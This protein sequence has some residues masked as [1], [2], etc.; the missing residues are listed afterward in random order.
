MEALE[1]RRLVSAALLK[2]I[3]PHS[4]GSISGYFTPFHDALYF[5]AR[6]PSGFE[7]YRSSGV[8]GAPVELVRDIVPGPDSSYPAY[9]TVVG[10][11]LFFRANV[12]RGDELWKSDGTAAGTVRVSDAWPSH[13]FGAGPRDL[14]ALN[15]TLLFVDYGNVLWKSAGTGASTVQFADTLD[16]AL[17]ATFG[18][19]TSRILVTG[20]VAYFQTNNPLT[21]RPGPLWKT[22]GTPAGTSAV[23]DVGAV[24]SLTRLDD[25]RFVIV[26]GDPRADGTGS[27]M[28]LWVS[29]GTPGGTAR[30]RSFAPY[31]ARDALFVQPVNLDGAV[32]FGAKAK[33]ADPGAAAGFELWRTDGTPEGTAL[34]A[35]VNPGLAGSQAFPLAGAG[36]KLLFNATD[37][38]GYRLWAT[39]GTA[40]GT[41]PAIGEA[42]YA[43]S[44]VAQGGKFIVATR[45]ALWVTDGT[46]AG[47]V[48]LRRF[49]PVNGPDV[50]AYRDGVIVKAQ[51]PV[52][53]EEPWFSD[54]T[55]EGTV[56]F[57]RVEPATL[58][59]YAI[60]GATM[61][62]PAVLGDR[63]MFAGAV[64]STGVKLWVTDGTT[65]GTAQVPGFSATSVPALRAGRDASGEFAYV[66]ARN[67]T[68]RELWRA[69]AAGATL[70]SN[71]LIAGDSILD[72]DGTLYFAGEQRSSTGVELYKSDG[73][74][75]GTTLVRDIFFTGSSQPANFRQA[76]GT[77]YFTVGNGASLYKT[78]GTSAGTVLVKE[79]HPGTGAHPAPALAAVGGRLY[80]VIEPAAGA[81]QLWRTDGSAAGTVMVT[82]IGAAL[83]GG[84][85]ML[86]IGDTLYFPAAA[87]DG[88]TGIELWKSDGTAAGTRA[89][90][91]LLPGAEGSRPANLRA[92]GGRVYFSA[93]D[94]HGGSALWA[95]DG[96]AA[97][98]VKVWEMPADQPHDLSRVWGERN[99]RLYFT[100]DDG[101]HG[102]ELWS[103]D[104]TPAGTAMVEDVR[105]GPEASGV[106]HP[107]DAGDRVIFF[108]DDGHHWQEPWVVMSP[109]PTAYVAGRHLFYNNSAFDNRTPGAAAADDAAIA[110]DRSAMVPGGGVGAVAANVSTYGRGI[111]GVMIDVDSLPPGAGLTAADFQLFVGN[112]PTLTAAPAP[113]S[114]TVRR[115][116]GANGSDR[117]TLLFADEAIQNTWLRVTVLP[118]ANTGLAA[119][120][121][122][123]FGSLAGDSGTDGRVDARDLAAVRRA[124]NSAATLTTATDLNRDGRTNA[125][126]LAIVRRNLNRA[127]ARVFL[128]SPGAAPPT[129]T[130]AAIPPPPP[131]TPLRPKRTTVLLETHGG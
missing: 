36:G 47:T 60:P 15:G 87:S 4:I 120:D 14:T 57:V 80:F 11:T 82:T 37:G 64:G 85:E 90:A 79:L 21:A 52:Y 18:S 74:A 27:D 113:L 1:P 3:N 39:D 68:A 115:G 23:A 40:A 20:G 76:G 55:V 6:G 128:P 46:P 45:D 104:G 118:T 125:L 19:L 2:D 84:R 50:I 25:N 112:G 59:T 131:R 91:D 35:D 103:T 31:D 30:V 61:P 33:A 130:A 71:V 83:P 70:L 75:A 126:D 77:V 53:G 26:T 63:A 110:P 28:E 51:D 42:A 129:V 5:S 12:G 92:M 96:T 73:T 124:L 29:D 67:G 123:V 105:R 109:T 24:Y 127:L 101:R 97:G 111:N 93:A 54:G 9:L 7:L 98:T 119:P 49:E 89:V 44:A 117:V 8:P 100:A 48:F 99:G 56:P 108:A 121:V 88:S 17:S 116:A 34:I 95:S 58:G 41:Q 32:Y 10:D 72:P 69:G 62:E 38:T 107:T 22:D 13:I 86:A 122:F 65:G 16:P 114:V 94:G 78:N 106:L 102:R 66:A 81:A 43:N